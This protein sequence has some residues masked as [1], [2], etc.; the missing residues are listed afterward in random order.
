MLPFAALPFHEGA[1]TWHVLHILVLIAACAAMP[2][3]GTARLAVFGVAALSRAVTVD[4]SLGNISVILLLPLSLAW[5]W[6]DRPGGSIAQVIAI[7]LRPSLGIIPI[8]QLLRRQ[9]RALIWTLGAGLALVVLTLPVVGL[10]GYTDYIALLRNL[11]DAIGASGNLD[12]GTTAHR[13]G[14]DDLTA[15]IALYAGYVIAIAAVL[16]SLRRDREVGFMVAVGA[17]LLLAPVL[18]DHYLALVVL[19][20]AML[21]V[22]GH[23]WALALP[24]LTWLPG[25]A[26]PFVALLATLL[27]FLARDPGTG[28]LT[29]RAAPQA[30][31]TEQ[32]PARA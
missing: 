20:A 23:P 14:A 3:S 5:R 12:L 31:S 22:R 19:P 7:S 15:T 10:E 29:D 11:S 16:F 6:L 26:Q 17:S 1:L 25:I 18:W 21:A 24:L 30:S 28:T 9:W 2:V 27:P 4:I 32:A 8:W 13:L